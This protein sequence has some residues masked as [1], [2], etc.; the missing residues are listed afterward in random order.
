[1]SDLYHG[2]KLVIEALSSAATADS[3]E[4]DDESSQKTV[5][6]SRGNHFERAVS[7]IS[8]EQKR[9]EKSMKNAERS[10][11][12]KEAKKKAKSITGI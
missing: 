8:D 2:Q 10:R 9:L 11:A 12:I 5:S 7:E 3:S 1:M 4:S 6:K